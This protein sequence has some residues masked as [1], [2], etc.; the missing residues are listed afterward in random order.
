MK[1]RLKGKDFTTK[2]YEFSL[3]PANDFKKTGEKL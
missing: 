3:K 1:R 2:L